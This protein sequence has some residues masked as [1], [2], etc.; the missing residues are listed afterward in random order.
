MIYRVHWW[1]DCDASQGFDFFGSEKE[2]KKAIAE[3]RRK[4]TKRDR[5]LFSPTID[6]FDTPKTKAEVLRLLAVV[7]VHPDN[8]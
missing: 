2:A 1:D 6:S 4:L 8:G 3:H 5:A 7:A